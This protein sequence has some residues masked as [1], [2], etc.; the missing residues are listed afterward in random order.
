MRM[1]LLLAGVLGCMAVVDGQDGVRGV[2]WRADSQE[3]AGSIIRARGHVRISHGNAVITA[4][5]ADV[6]DGVGNPDRPID[7]DLRGN[8]HVQVI[9][10][11]PK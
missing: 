3:R 7:I 8:V 6:I 1:F 2:A 4:D 5:E 11:T 9:I 10:P